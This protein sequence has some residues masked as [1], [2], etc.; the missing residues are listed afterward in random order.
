M[1]LI[2]DINNNNKKYD[3]LIAKLQITI[4]YLCVQKKN[5][6]MFK[7]IC[8]QN[9]SQAIEKCHKI[10]FEVNIKTINDFRTFSSTF[11][12]RKQCFYG[13]S[14]KKKKSSQQTCKQLLYWKNSY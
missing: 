9:I 2:F 11:Y 14:I 13:F 4:N 7:F 5:S 12:N 6:R 8:F 1:Y 10:P 3:I